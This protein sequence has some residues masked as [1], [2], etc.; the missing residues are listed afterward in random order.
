MA[1][2]P[3]PREACPR[4]AANASPLHPWSLWLLC[5]VASPSLSSVLLSHHRKHC[6]QDLGLSCSQRP[7]WLA[8]L[9]GGQLPSW[10]V[11]SGHIH[12][13]EEAQM[14]GSQSQLPRLAHG[15][16]WGGWVRA[17]A[18]LPPCRSPASVTASSRRPASGL[19]T[20]PRAAQQCSRSRSSSKWTSRTLRAGR[21]R[22]RTAST[23]SRSRFCQVSPQAEGTG[24]GPPARA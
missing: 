16:R 11:P 12:V 10:W 14:G 3:C 22:R 13:T 19:S 7:C 20:R 4:E 24:S 8:L 21:H 6:P 9:G 15:M 2:W 5:G 1:T 17:H 23:P 18:P